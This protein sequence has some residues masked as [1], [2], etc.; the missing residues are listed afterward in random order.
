MKTQ[1]TVLL[2]FLF[3]NLTAQKFQRC[4]IEKQDGA[5]IHGFARMPDPQAKP[6]QYKK[7]EDGDKEVLP[8][9]DLKR[10]ILY[11]NDTVEFSREDIVHQGKK[12][13]RMWLQKHI[14]G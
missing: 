9:D 8:S 2:C 6:V 10:V 13:G 1:I 3:F 12:R 4:L 7:D 5:Q 14:S 11:G